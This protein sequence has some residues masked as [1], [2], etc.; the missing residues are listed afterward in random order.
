M[1]RRLVNSE[2]GMRRTAALAGF[3]LVILALPALCQE[4]KIEWQENLAAALEKAGKEG[5]L[6]FADFTGKEN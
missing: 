2:E 3:L 4:K 6:V 5:K 1:S